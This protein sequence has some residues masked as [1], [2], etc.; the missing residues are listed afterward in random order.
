[1]SQLSQIQD[2]NWVSIPLAKFSHNTCPYGTTSFVWV[3]VQNK[4]DLD[5]VIRK[6]RV[7]NSLGN[8]EEQIGMKVASRAE[9]LV[10]ILLNL[11]TQH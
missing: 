11:L 1:M 4:N 5:L 6:A 7:V 3:H 10:R 8:Y 9:I 2:P